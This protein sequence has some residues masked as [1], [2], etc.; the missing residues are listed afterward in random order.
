MSRT[1]TWLLAAAGLFMAAP[2]SAQEFNF[3]VDSQA[4]QA[5]GIDSSQIEGEMQ[6]LVE[7]TFNLS[8]HED[9]VRQMA[10]AS[11]ISTKGMGLDYGSNFNR[12]IIGGSFGSGVAGNGLSLGSGEGSL[13][14]SGFSLQIAGMVGLNLG[15]FSDDESPLRRFKLYANYMQMPLNQE[16][17]EGQLS[18]VGAHIQIDVVKP[19]EVTALTWGGLSFNTGYTR[20]NYKL[21]LSKS[22]PVDLDL[23]GQ[24]IR[25]DASGNYTLSAGTTTI[26]LELSTNLQMLKILSIFGGAGLDIN[27]GEA[28]SRGAIGGDLTATSANDQN[29]GDMS[30]KLEV[31]EAPTDFSEHIFL[32]AQLN[33]LKFR[34]YGQATGSLSGE[35]FGGNVGLRFGI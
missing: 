11:V 4:S 14:E 1:H 7:Q 2:A 13:P 12:F 27:G 34:L 29:L 21:E 5:L 15:M 26:P 22:L 24:T 18:N 19:R 28:G 35:S 10:N 6:Q 20:A 33:V 30:L 9:F 31:V 3:N 23:S 17:F 32:G 8:D 16:P 25:W